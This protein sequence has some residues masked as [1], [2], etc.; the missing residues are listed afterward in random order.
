MGVAADE[1]AALLQMVAAAKA[2][3]DFAEY[4]VRRR[5]DG[6]VPLCLD[7]RGRGCC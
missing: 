5:A 7:E 1:R 3:Y 2:G 4:T 6:H